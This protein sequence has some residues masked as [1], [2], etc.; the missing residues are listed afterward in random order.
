M[1]KR[2]IRYSENLT[3]IESGV[4]ESEVQRVLRMSTSTYNQQV[5]IIT[6]TLYTCNNRT[7]WEDQVSKN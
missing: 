3:A 2:S 7:F 4:S 6:M 5:S 1:A